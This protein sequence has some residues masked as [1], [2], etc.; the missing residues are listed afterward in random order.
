[1]RSERSHNT[2]SSCPRQ[3]PTLQARHREELFMQ[4]NHLCRMKCIEAIERLSSSWVDLSTLLQVRQCM[5]SHLTA[6]RQLRAPCSRQ[7][8]DAALAPAL[9]LHAP[10]PAPLRCSLGA[11][12]HPIVPRLLAQLQQQRFQSAERSI[13]QTAGVP[14]AQD[15]SCV[16]GDAAARGQLENTVH[17]RCP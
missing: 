5:A 3:V 6:W 1:V 10:V 7:Q 12:L 16:D 2:Q 4:S 9:C 14:S 13:A 17:V 15:S 8:F 11:V